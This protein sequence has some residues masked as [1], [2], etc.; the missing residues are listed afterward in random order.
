[1]Y[2]GGNYP[3]EGLPPDWDILYPHTPGLSSNTGLSQIL[4][5]R[6]PG[7]AG[8]GLGRRK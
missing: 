7:R 8:A 4:G 2:G 5:S 6:F 1:M 3:R